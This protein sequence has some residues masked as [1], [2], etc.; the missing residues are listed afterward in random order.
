MASSPVRADEVRK[1]SEETTDCLTGTQTWVQED[2]I[3]DA[4]WRRGSPEATL[5][6]AR[7]WDP[8]EDGWLKNKTL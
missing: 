4:D 5:K 8:K 1:G 3:D 2:F 6:K 7:L